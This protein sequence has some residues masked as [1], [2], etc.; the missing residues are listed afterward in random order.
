MRLTHCISIVLILIISTSISSFSQVLHREYYESGN[1]KTTIYEEWGRVYVVQYH[2]NGRLAQKGI[3]A[4]FKKDGKFQSWHENGSKYMEIEFDG[5]K[6]SGEWKIWDENGQIIILAI[7]RN[8]KFNSGSQ[9]DES[10][11]LV[12]QR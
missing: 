3:Y 1:L 7:Y 2:E 9:W 4:D 6:P 5:N 11:N 8:G 12:A 10:G